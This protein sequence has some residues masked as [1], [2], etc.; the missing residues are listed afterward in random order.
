MIEQLPAKASPGSFI[1]I[2]ALGGAYARVPE[3]Q[4]AFGGSR[5][6]RWALN[7]TA[8]ARDKD[9]FAHDRTWVRD[10][11]AELRPYANSSGSYI[12]FLADND[13]ERIRASYGEKYDRLAA[14][15]ATWDPNNVFHHNANIRPA[16]NESAP[17]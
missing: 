9:A 1:P 15:K 6:T 8:I 16:A 11:W 12:N 13:E 4:T 17:E 3:D 10:F 5:Q 14:I 2:F 7:I